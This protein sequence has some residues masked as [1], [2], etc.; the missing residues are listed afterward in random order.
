[1]AELETG[2][3]EEAVELLTSGAGGEEM[4]FIPG[5]W[6]TSGLELLTQC[7]LASGRRADAERTAQH[8]ADCAATVGLPMAAALAARAAAHVALDGGDAAGAG[9][10]ALASAAGLEELG[11][12]YPAAASRLIAGRALGAAGDE[13]RAAAELER[14]AEAFAS[15]GSDRYRA[16]AEQELRKLGRTSTTARGRARARAWASTRSPSA[17]WRWRG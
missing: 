14:A 9:E 1:M 10:Q 7:L 13:D 12:L 16:Q 2:H 8:A 17:S 4:L 3:P 15:F 5:G 11:A 6:R